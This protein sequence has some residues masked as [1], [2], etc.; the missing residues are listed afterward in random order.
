MK[1]PTL[2]LYPTDPDFLIPNQ[3]IVGNIAQTGL[4]D[5]GAE[6]RLMPNEIK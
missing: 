6:L 2:S 3:G 5:L 4:T 1:Q